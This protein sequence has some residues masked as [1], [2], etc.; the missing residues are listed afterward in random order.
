MCLKKSLVAFCLVFFIISCENDTTIVF[1]NSNITTED[2]SIV[3][4]NI[5]IASGNTEI[6]SSINSALNDLIISILQ[7]GDIE[8]SSP[9]S[10]EES[11][12][13][14]NQEYKDFIT[15]FP[16]SSQHWEAQI[17]GEVIHQ[18]S[19]IISIATT[20]YINTGGA[21]GNLN[22]SLINF[23]AATGN[24]ISNTNLFKN[25]NNLKKMAFPYFNEAI[26]EK[27]ILLES[28]SF[29]LPANIAYSKEGI[30]FLYNAYEIASYSTG[31]IE[32]TIP[33]NVI[34]SF[35]VFK[36]S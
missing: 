20:S 16:D 2:N 5:P 10:I 11:I 9:K 31:I 27:D 33:Y 3:A 19:E 6:L 23:N 4:I 8:D 18:S 34:N 22:I 7:I 12:T 1:L 24:L 30:I 25:I 32:F 36:G 21:H 14:F 15:D 13:A 17:D 28:N 26:K 29:E 35:L